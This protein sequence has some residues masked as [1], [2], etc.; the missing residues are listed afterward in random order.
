VKLALPHTAPASWGQ[1]VGYRKDGRPFYAIRGGSQDYLG[2][3]RAQHADALNT[4]ASITTRASSTRNADGELV[5]LTDEDRTA[6]AELQ[7][8]ATRMAGDIELLAQDVSLSQQT[9]QRLAQVQAGDA[10]SQY[11][12]RGELVIDKVKASQ[13]DASAVGRLENYHRAAQHMGTT[14]ANTT[15]TAGSL[16]GLRV[17]P[18]VGPVIDVRPEFRPL[19][20]ALGVTTVASPLGFRRPR[21]NVPTGMVA[22][23]TLEKAELA[24]KAYTVT[25][26]SVEMDTYGGYLNLSAQLLALEA[27]ALATTITV[28]ESE[29]GK[30]QELLTIAA[31]IENAD[32]TTTLAANATPAQLLAAIFTASRKVYG[33]TGALGTHLA[34]GPEGW[35][36]LGSLVD[37]AGRP[38]FPAVTPVNA[39][40][41]LQADSFTGGTIAGLQPVITPGITGG[42]LFVLNAAGIEAYEYPLPV[43]EAVEPSVLGRQ[44]AVASVFGTYR[45]VAGGVARLAP[46]A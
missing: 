25:A 13:G 19:L 4:I 32:V 3:L 21:L 44:V 40:G 41:S 37:A 5:G 38:L 30:V 26:E 45:P 6:I 14:V 31:M 12:N 42:D 8:D 28:M 10:P 2:R 35:A 17:D 18:V 7:A 24:S 43:F 20:T 9:R 16:E 36:R 34:M 11:R 27:T 33:A 29:L 39:I 22:K 15:P 23:Q 46:A 1:P